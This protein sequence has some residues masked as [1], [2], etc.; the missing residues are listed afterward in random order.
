MTIDFADLKEGQ[1][2]VRS[3]DGQGLLLITDYKGGGQSMVPVTFD[4]LAHYGR[5]LV[6]NAQH[7]EDQ[8]GWNAEQIMCIGKTI[9][10]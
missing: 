6:K 4:S 8:L 2:I 3:P 9:S 5:W 1:A 7:L 10:Q